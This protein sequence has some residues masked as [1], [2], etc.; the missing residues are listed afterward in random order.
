MAR[1]IKIGM[2][3]H[4]TSYTLHALEPSLYDDELVLGT[5]KIGASAKNVLDVIEKLK[6]KLPGDVEIE[7]GYEVGCLGFS[8]HNELTSAGVKCTILAPT[9][10]LS[11]QCKRVKT[12]AR[13]AEMIAQ[14][15]AYGG[16]PA[17]AYPDGTGSR[18]EKVHSD[19]G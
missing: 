4:S 1:I 9:T 16:I 13:D 14:C 5:W 2:D 7:C 3:V 6:K 12:D 11:P 17:G 15:L 10:M 19:A 18:R 8:L